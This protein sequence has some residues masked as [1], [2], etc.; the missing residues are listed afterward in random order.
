M[1]AISTE[2]ITAWKAF[3]AGEENVHIV[4]G[5]ITQV[6]CDAIVSP[7]NSFGFM[8]GGLDY[9]LSVRL[10]WELEKKL[11][12]RIARLPMGELLVGQA[13]LMDTGDAGI[14]YLIS[15]PTMRVPTNFNIPTSVN[16]YLAMKAILVCA[17]TEPR[18][19]TVAIP[20]LATGTGRMPA[21][22]CARQMYEAYRETVLGHRPHFATFGEAQKHHREL[23]PNGMIWTH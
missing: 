5:D 4:E 2:L 22:V 11:Q 18:I 19:Q 20:G 17:Q 23:N 9:A 6:P 14:P 16:A 1:A 3:F 15:A 8:D 21:D 13:L 10:G 7:A 12:A